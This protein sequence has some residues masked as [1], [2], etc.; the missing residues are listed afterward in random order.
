[1]R[2][3]SLRMQSLVEDMLRLVQLENGARAVRAQDLD[4]QPWLKRLIAEINGQ[5]PESVGIVLEEMEDVIVKELKKYYGVGSP[6]PY[7]L[8]LSAARRLVLLFTSPTIEAH[9]GEL[10]IT[11]QEGKGSRSIEGKPFA[12]RCA[13]YGIVGK[14]L[15]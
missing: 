8:V 1:M 7:A 13:E 10:Q 4:L 3:H 15:P 5:F 14:A 2:S 12:I 11:S 6:C 9:G